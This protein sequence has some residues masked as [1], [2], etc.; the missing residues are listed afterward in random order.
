MFLSFSLALNIYVCV[1]VEGDARETTELCVYVNILLEDEHLGKKKNVS[2]ICYILT[3][4]DHNFFFILIQSILIH[5][6]EIIT[7]KTGFW[8]LKT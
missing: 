7:K 2:F 4:C 8:L 6:L 5:F 1:C 3:I